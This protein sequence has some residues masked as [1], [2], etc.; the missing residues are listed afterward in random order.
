MGKI[1]G[2][3]RGDGDEKGAGVE[4]A[5]VGKGAGVEEGAGAGKGAGEEER[6]WVGKAVGGEEG[7]GLEKGVGGKEEVA[8]DLQGAAKRKAEKEVD[9]R[10]IKKKGEENSKK[11]KDLETDVNPAIKTVK[12]SCQV[13]SEGKTDPPDDE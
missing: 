9:K 6:A 3:E 12:K 11:V 10:N 7:A 8:G 13:I 1:A 4:G 2:V 5:G